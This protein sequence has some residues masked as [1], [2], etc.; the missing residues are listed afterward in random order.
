MEKCDFC[1]Y[2]RTKN[3]IRDIFKIPQ[4]IIYAIHN[5]IA[6]FDEKDYLI[7]CKEF[8]WSTGHYQFRED[9]CWILK[10]GTPLD[11]SN[12]QQVTH[13]TYPLPEPI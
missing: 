9:N 8:G 12:D 13:W 7:Y 4:D 3:E 6:P 10:D 1:S 2:F 5:G 11:A